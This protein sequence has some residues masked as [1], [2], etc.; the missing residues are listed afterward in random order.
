MRE[1]A[2]FFAGV[3][4]WEAVVHFSL[5]ANGMLP[6]TWFGLITL[7]PELNA[8]QVVV[9]ILFSVGLAAYTW[10]PR[11]EESGNLPRM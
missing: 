11:R 5:A 6:L 1:L 4:F 3:T 2:K 10:L 8:L 7:T 9:P